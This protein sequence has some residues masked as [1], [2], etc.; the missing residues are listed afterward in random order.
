MKQIITIIAIVCSVCTVK[1]QLNPYYIDYNG[2]K[3]VTMIAFPSQEIGGVQL[4]TLQVYAISP[5]ANYY[6]D[7]LNECQIRSL[8]ENK[9][10]NLSDSLVQNYI[11]GKTVIHRQLYIQDNIIHYKTSNNDWIWTSSHVWNCCIAFSILFLV[12]LIR[13]DKRVTKV[14]K[15]EKT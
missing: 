6:I 13:I 9:S 12:A 14:I 11:I 7:P 3:I 1:G 15:N 2:E 8:I 5:K 10:Y 4:D